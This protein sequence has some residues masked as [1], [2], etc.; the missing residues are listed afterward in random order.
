M[1]VDSTGKC[2]NSTSKLVVVPNMADRWG[3]VGTN[4]VQ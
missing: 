3:G 2:N 4:F 1:N